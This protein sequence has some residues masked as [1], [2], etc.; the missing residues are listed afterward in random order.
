M[1]RTLLA[2]LVLA[3][4]LPALQAG[5]APA[6]G[7]EVWFVVKVQGGE[8][9]I[10]EYSITVYKDGKARGEGPISQ[11]KI[12]GSYTFDGSFDKS[13]RSLTGTMHTNVTFAPGEEP[14]SVHDWHAAFSLNLVDSRNFTGTASCPGVTRTIYGFGETYTEESPGFDSPQIGQA[15]RDV[16]EGEGTEEGGPE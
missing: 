3:L 6:Q 15:D 2:I 9:G 8:G 10:Y 13:S 5:P 7:E 11:P 14:Y 4:L 12:E 1:K 16:F